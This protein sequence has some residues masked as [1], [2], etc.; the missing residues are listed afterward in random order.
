[1][2]REVLDPILA[3]AAREAGADVR[4]GEAVT[5]LLRT[6]DRV[7]GVRTDKGDVEARLV[8][9]ADGRTSTIAKLAGARRYNLV[10]NERAIYWGY[11]EG[12]D[13]GPE[14]TFVFHRW[15]NRAHVASPTDGGLYCSQLMID[16][17]EVDVFKS[18]IEASFMER[19]A[20][21]EPVAKALDGARLVG[22][23]QGQLKWDGFFREARGPGWVLTGDAGHFKD[24]APGRGIADAF[25]QADFLAAH[26]IRGDFDEATA[27]F[28]RWR[29]KEFAQYYWFG[30]DQGA[31]GELP[32]VVPAV[33][34][35]LHRKGRAE[36]LL[37]IT[38]HRK[39]P[40]QVL[41]P[42]TMLGAIGRALRK[43]E[44]PR[45][46]VLREARDQALL[47]MRRRRLERRP[48]Y[49]G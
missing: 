49:E 11:F 41:N 5:E 34:A 48:R 13:P 4:F 40:I 43:G 3:N 42:P 29:D 28:A 38:N 32:A 7:T 22:K 44:I 31:G 12:A 47:D 16:L 19:C 26:L 33:V 24:P 2:R 46:Q 17:G 1:V 14:P 37:E 25:L 36:E 10:P 15:G 23:I 18:D 35:D 30:S 21:C 45:R 9:G 39:K 8:I 6:G 20:T 27:R